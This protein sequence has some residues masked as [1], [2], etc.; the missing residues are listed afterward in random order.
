MSEVLRLSGVGRIK[1][2]PDTLLTASKRS[3]STSL[4]VSRGRIP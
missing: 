3:R 1:Q 4:T 2:Q